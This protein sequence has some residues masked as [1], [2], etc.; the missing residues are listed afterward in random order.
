MELCN[1]QC[2]A[3]GGTARLSTGTGALSALPR[4]IQRSKPYMRR[5]RLNT[6]WCS[7]LL[8]KARAPFKVICRLSLTVIQSAG[9]Q[10]ADVRHKLL[11]PEPTTL[12]ADPVCRNTVSVIS[13]TQCT[14]VATRWWRGRHRSLALLREVEL[15]RFAMYRSGLT[16]YLHHDQ[17]QVS[18]QVRAGVESAASFCMTVRPASG[19][20]YESNPLAFG[21]ASDN[22]GRG[23]LIDRPL[24]ANDVTHHS[25]EQISEPDDQRQN[26]CQQGI[27][28]SPSSLSGLALDPAASKHGTVR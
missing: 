12:C 15:R 27:A 14:T 13:R 17:A 21:Q 4:G 5:W 10:A 26:R 28:Q 6:K 20:A 16:R 2:Y 22:P 24:Q 8:R 19:A 1:H 9:E 18:A 25:A 7:T 23:R 11:A 3:P